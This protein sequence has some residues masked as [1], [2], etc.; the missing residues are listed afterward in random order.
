[1]KSTGIVRRIDSLGRICI[2]KEL[3]TTLRIHEGDPLEFSVEGNRIGLVKQVEGAIGDHA[4]AVGANLLRLTG[5]PVLICDID[6]VVY[7]AGE[8]VK[9]LTGRNISDDL[10]QKTAFLCSKGGKEYA[11]KPFQPVP[12]YRNRAVCVVPI[13]NN[14]RIVFGSIL[15]MEGPE[16]KPPV[17]SLVKIVL[18]A[19]STI[20]ALFDAQ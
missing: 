14:E 18:A 8:P 7:A 15:L 19:A 16:Q 10:H 2:P 3:R 9:K 11:V 17:N 12:G 13:I 1:M 20:G 4:Q 5:Y 6:K